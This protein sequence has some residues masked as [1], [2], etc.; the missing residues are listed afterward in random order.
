M[1][2]EQQKRDLLSREIKKDIQIEWFYSLSDR[3]GFMSKQDRQADYMRVLQ[4]E[5]V[6]DKLRYTGFW[7]DQQAKLYNPN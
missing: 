5:L 6:A 4:I 1:A 7:H 3:M 2:T